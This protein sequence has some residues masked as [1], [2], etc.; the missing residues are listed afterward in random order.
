VFPAT[1]HYTDTVTGERRRH[2]L[3][4]SVLQ[5]AVKVARLKA[6][7]AKPAGP[8]TVAPFIFFFQAEDGIRDPDGPGTLGTQRGQHHD[9]LHPRVES[10][11]EGSP[12]PG[13]FSVGVGAEPY[14]RYIGI[15]AVS[16]CWL[17]DTQKMLDKSLK[18]KKIPV[19]IEI[20]MAVIY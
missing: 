12:K 16:V 17:D 10:R 11:R 13:R 4:E 3:H 1:S 2:H 5:R 9:D 6:G 8:N 18:R 20:G 19:R 7:I 15:I 14:C